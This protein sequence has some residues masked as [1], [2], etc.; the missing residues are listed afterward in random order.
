MNFLTHN[1][2]IS[3]SGAIAI[4]V[5]EQILPLLPIKPNSTSQLGL[6]ILKLIFGKR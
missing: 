2:T 3:I 1:P 5:L 6:S 4:I